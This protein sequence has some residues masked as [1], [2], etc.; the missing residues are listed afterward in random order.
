[1]YMV[2]FS[3][4]RLLLCS[5]RFDHVSIRY[6][7]SV[8]VLNQKQIGTKTICQQNKNRYEQNYVNKTKIG[9]NITKLTEQEQICTELYKQNNNRYEKKTQAYKY[10]VSK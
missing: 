4:L 3:T 10:T 2:L 7:Y 6:L 9:I 1:M 8:F 5:H